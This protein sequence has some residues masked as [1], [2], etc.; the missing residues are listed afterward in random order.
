M[1]LILKGCETQ[2]NSINIKIHKLKLFLN[3]FAS[4]FFTPHYIFFI[5]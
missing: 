2:T 5:K 4:L 1:Q 3:K